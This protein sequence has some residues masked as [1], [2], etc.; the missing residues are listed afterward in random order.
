MVSALG[1]PKDFVRKVDE[2]LPQ[3]K[4]QK[5]VF[6]PYEGY[7]SAIDTRAVGL[8][9]INLNGGRTV[10]NQKLNLATG[11]TGFTQIGDKVD[12]KTPLAMVHY[13][14]EAQY[15]RAVDELLAAIKFSDSQPAV[16]DPILL[17]M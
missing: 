15:Q 12:T 13:Q 3:S 4:H 6:A 8:S 11:Y 10:P 16:T 2:Y 7:V 14:T 9:I 5:P 17:K 1:G